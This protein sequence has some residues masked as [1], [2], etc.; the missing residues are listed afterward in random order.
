MFC[1]LQTGIQLGGVR[2]CVCL[3]NQCSVYYRLGFRWVEQGYV[4]VLLTNV[5]CITDGDSG[6][7]SKAMCMSC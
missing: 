2:L 6:G 7:W 3:V 5:L 1:V 4:Y